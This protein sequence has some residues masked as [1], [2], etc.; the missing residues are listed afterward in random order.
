MVNKN[1]VFFL[2]LS[3]FYIES[4]FPQNILNRSKF[5]FSLEYGSL[6]PHHKMM[7]PLAEQKYFNSRLDIF[8][9][10]RKTKLWH[11]AYNYPE[12]GATLLYSGMS[13]PSSLGRAFA[14][15]PFM[16]FKINNSQKI[17]HKVYFGLGLGYL[18]KTFD[19][20]D[21]YKNVAIGSHFNAAMRIFYSFE[22]PFSNRLGLETGF[23][24]THFSNGAISLPN[25]GVNQMSIS[26]GIRYQNKKN[27]G[28]IIPKDSC[29]F[30]KSI[31][32]YFY[33]F[34]GIKQLY[35]GDSKRYQAFSFGSAVEWRYR[36]FKAA[37]CGIDLFYDASDFAFFRD[38]GHE[39]PFSSFIKS[40][41]YIGHQWYF[42]RLSFALNFG[43]YIYS[44]HK[45][46][47]TGDFYNRLVLRYQVSNVLELNSSLKAHFAKAD[48]IEWGLVYKPF[49]NITLKNK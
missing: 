5:S 48:Y 23:G 49:R 37:L 43:T 3:I 6:L 27:E 22:V 10:S 9:N 21:N 1:T 44:K 26:L 12:T 24:I 46:G 34:T 17:Q 2:L 39:Y 7:Y 42:D 19:R 15:L 4:V 25:R 45:V 47:D 31:L 8:I 18:T 36:S 38:E 41:F 14:V 32:P 28:I 35:V 30:Q 29:C 16:K 40:G 13:S 11:K 20:L 33:L